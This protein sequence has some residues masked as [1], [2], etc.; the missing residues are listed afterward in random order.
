MNIKNAKDLR[1]F[2]N[3]LTEEQLQL[4]VLFDTEARTFNYHMAEIG[5]VYCEDQEGMGDLAHI[6]LHEKRPS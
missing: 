2:L 4:P 3:S 6:G 1:D 5:Q